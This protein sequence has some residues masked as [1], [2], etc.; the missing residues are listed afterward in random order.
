MIDG[1]YKRQERD[2]PIVVSAAEVKDLQSKKPDPS[3][4]RRAIEEKAADRIR[5]RMVHEGV[6]YGV[7]VTKARELGYTLE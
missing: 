5:L 3:L 1:R 2:V 7:A 4:V 6:R